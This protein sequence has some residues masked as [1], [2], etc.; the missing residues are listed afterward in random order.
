MRA[1]PSVLAAFLL[2]VFVSAAPMAASA[3]SGPDPS[4]SV[5]KVASV[6]ADGS[7]LNHYT[8][9]VVVTNVGSAGQAGNVLQSV[10]VSHFD[11]KV[12]TK[13]IPPLKAGASYVWMY[14]FKRNADAGK[15]TTTLHFALD[16]H[17]KTS[18]DCNSGNDSYNLTF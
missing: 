1:A 8:I 13:G 3:C 6:S 10:N 15:G 16:M 4:L 14:N 7:G 11:N 17:G 12:D 2:S 5:V 9:K 18:A